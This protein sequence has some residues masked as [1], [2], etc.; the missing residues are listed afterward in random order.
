LA[1]CARR[2]GRAILVALNHRVSGL[3]Q[4]N[5]GFMNEAFCW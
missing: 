1:A 3:V 2:Y 5:V 4:R